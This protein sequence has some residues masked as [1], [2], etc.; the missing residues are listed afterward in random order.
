MEQQPQHQQSLETSPRSSERTRL[1]TIERAIERSTIH[2]DV[3]ACIWR[4]LLGVAV[5]IVA[6]KAP[7]SAEIVL[8]KLLPLL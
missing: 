8:K 6:L 3:A 5:I 7:E 1:S 4:V 2:F